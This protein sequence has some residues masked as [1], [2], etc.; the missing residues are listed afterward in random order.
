M[1]VKLAVFDLA[2]T[3]VKDDNAVASAFCKAFDAYG[4]TVSEEAVRPLMGYKKPV[5]IQIILEKMGIETDEELVN[6]IHREFE[7]EMIDHYEYS[8]DVKAI[9]GAE[10]VML[11]LKEKG[12]R[13]ALNTG[14]TKIIADTILH[15]LQWREK[16]IADDCIASDE[17]EEGRPQ[18]FMIRALMERAGIDDPKEVVKIGDTEADVNEGR[19]ADCA[20]VIA[21]TT[22]AFAKEQL[23]TYSPDYIIDNLSELPPLIFDCD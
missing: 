15:R 17:V 20:L 2:G 9:P 4:Y 1:P 5:A 21:V 14:F 18:P 19:N 12:I 10:M 8:P 3:T 23:E 16:G 13:V 11:Q 6:D 22:G 7:M